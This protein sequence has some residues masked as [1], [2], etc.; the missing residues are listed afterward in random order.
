MEP[1]EQEMKAQEQNWEFAMTLSEKEG[2]MAKNTLVGSQLPKP[3]LEFN[4]ACSGCGETPYIRLL[5]QLFGERM[6]IAN[7]TGCSS[8]WGA[9]P[10]SI[11][12][13]TTSKGRGPAWANS[14]FEDNPEYG[15]GMFLAVDQIRDRILELM[16]DVLKTDAPQKMK[17]AFRTWIEQKEDGPGSRKAADDILSLAEG[18]GVLVQSVLAKILE[19]KEYLVK[20]S[21]W[22]IGGD[23]WAYDIGFG[24]LDHVLSTGEDVN[25]FVM[26]TEIY[27]NTGGQSSKA[28]PTA[29]I[30]KFVAKGKQT[31]KKDLGLMAMSYGDVYVAQIAM[32]AN[33]NHTLKA[34]VEAESYPGPSLI[35][36]YSPCVSHGIKS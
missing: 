13:M 16:K 5:T 4:G 20:R 32:G 36:G 21:F 17:D 14:L 35:I 8:I 7:A 19:Y 34:I 22:M 29:A 18:H 24:G 25:L 6:M 1:S 31:R 30:A 10:P 3:L 2:L 23:G 9:S 28:T 15:Y 12:Y 27:S 11:A 33:M 26:D